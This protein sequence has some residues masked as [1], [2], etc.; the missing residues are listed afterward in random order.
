MAEKEQ[1]DRLSSYEADDK[2]AL[3]H[4]KKIRREKCIK[5][6]S[7][8]AALM[9][10]QAI[11]III[12]AFTV[13][14]V[15]DPI[16]KVNSVTVT[17]IDLIN[18][19][20]PRPGTNMSVIAD[21]S[22]KNPNVASFKHGNT[23]SSLYYRGTLVGEARGP[24]GQSKARR[25]TRMNITVDIITDRLTSNP[26]LKSDVG[27]GL[28]TMSSFSRVGGRVKIMK[29]IKRNVIVTMNCTT[30]VNISTQAILKQQ[31]KRHVKL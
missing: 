5:C 29:I 30:T 15:K 11:V 24:P 26:N 18:G 8:V 20:I 4:L 21:V 9:L 23:T 6:C 1:V 31:C 17:R 28:L 12:L 7:C 10:V 2:E 14:R 25:T 27:S 22:V 3:L 16:I 19:T 13:F